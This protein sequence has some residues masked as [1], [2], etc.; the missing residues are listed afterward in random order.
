MYQA[1]CE[2]T[3]WQHKGKQTQREMSHAFVEGL[4]S[5]GVGCDKII[6]STMSNSNR[7]KCWEGDKQS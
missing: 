4:F 2:A 7:V 6:I 1:L 5:G 3:Q